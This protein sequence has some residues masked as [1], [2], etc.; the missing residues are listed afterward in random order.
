[1]TNSGFIMRFVDVVL[2]MLFGFITISNLQDT[3]VALPESAETE[4]MPIDSE[5]IEFIG[6]LP[7]GTFLIEDEQTKISSI[8]ML[9]GYLT[10]RVALLQQEARLKVRIRSSWDAP[11]HYAL[12]VAALCDDMGIQKSLEVELNLSGD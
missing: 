11:V 6:I 10:R 8:E 7:D 12:D 5:E 1:M 4:P 3:D 2:I 9:R